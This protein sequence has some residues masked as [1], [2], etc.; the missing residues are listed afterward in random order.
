MSIES[1]WE[2]GV[3][4][5]DDGRLS[6]AEAARRLGIKVETLYAYVSRGLLTSTRVPGGR[7]STFAIGDLDRL[8][9]SGSRPRARD[10]EPFRFP[11]ISTTVT[12]VRDGELSYRGRSVPLLS[13]TESFEAVT[14]LLWGDTDAADPAT[15]WTLPTATATAVRR[16][17]RALPPTLDRMTYLRVA[18]A[19]AAALDPLRHDLATPTVRRT[20]RLAIAALVDGVST[21]GRRLPPGRLAERLLAALTGS[22]PTLVPCLEAALVLLADHGLA[23]STVAARVAASARADPYAVIGAGLGALDSP[24][25]GAASV[26][27][28]ALLIE[29]DGGLDPGAAIGARLRRGAGIPGIGH[30]LYAHGDPRAAALFGR[31]ATVPAAGRWLTAARAVEATVAG[32]GGESG[33]HRANIDLA[34]AVL[35]LTGDLPADAGEVIFGVARTAGWIAHAVEEYR[36]QPLR[37]RGR[38]LYTGA[39]P[40]A[41]ETAADSR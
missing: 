31:L 11:A 23:T 25:H 27:A 40:P 24:L 39:E 37:W 33:A 18:L 2:V 17:V 38:E 16:V 15:D 12:L 7:G 34:L 26:A 5:G 29:V 3:A 19:T 10:T 30:S 4:P 35:T 28:R 21:G 36:E 14:A 32:R 13:A 20:A 8:A 9:D 22:D 6:S 41:P 1:M